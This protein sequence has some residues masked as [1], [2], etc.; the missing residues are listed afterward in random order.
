[1]AHIQQTRRC[2]FVISNK[3]HRRAILSKVEWYIDLLEDHPFEIGLSLALIL[4]GSRA[5]LTDLQAAPGSVQ[6]LPDALAF[7]YCILSVLG[8]A[9]VIFGLA[10]RIRFA[11]AYG[12]ER[13]GLFVSASAWASYIVGLLL[14]PIT[15]RSTL[16]IFAL[17]ALSIG[18][19]LRARA[20]NRRVKALMFALRIAGSEKEGQ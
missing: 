3:K 12:A 15:G 13:F 11:W 10:A 2:N 9:A 7:S 5:L 16:L 6:D 18:C 20:V 17:S 1:M 19:L 4:F 8:G 14:N